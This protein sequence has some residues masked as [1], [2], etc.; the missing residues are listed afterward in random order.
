MINIPFL[1]IKSINIRFKQEL[2]SSL[3]K[4][5]ESG[6]YVLEEEV[7]KFEQEFAN[8]CG[9]KQFIGVGNGLDALFMVLKAWGIGVGDEVIVPSNTYIA[10]WLAVSNLGATPVPVEP[11]LSDCNINPSLIEEKITSKTKAIIAVHLYGQPADMGIIMDIA[12]RH[13]LKV[14]EDAAQAHGAKYFSKNVGSLAHAAAFSFYPGKNLGA[15]GD[16]GGI[17][18]DD[19]ELS[20]SIRMMRNYGSKLKYVNE[21]RGVNSRLDEIQAA[22]LRVKLKALDDDNKARSEIAS[23]YY[24]GLQNVK[25][26]RLPYVCAN[27]THVWHLFV[28]Q[29][30]DRD[31]LQQF[32]LKKGIHTM[33]HYPI[34]P[35][36]QSAYKDLGYQIG[37]FP[38]SESLHSSVLSLPMGPTM[39]KEEALKVVAAVRSFYGR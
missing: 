28:V 30:F 9:V 26:I 16:A 25:E 15:L 38:V 37:S 33:I 17:S 22:F 3:S 39:K 29:C 31:L 21:I 19:Y 1:D 12:K 18:T 23:L 32:L 5:I 35:H 10:T 8:Y 20:N 4:V 6:W 36:L 14:L 24:N 27:R 7:D 2:I 11:N 34:A 13:N